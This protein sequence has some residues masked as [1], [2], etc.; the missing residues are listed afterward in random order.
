MNLKYKKVAVGGTFDLLHA[1]HKALLNKAV[2]VGE[3]VIIGI[4]TDKFIQKQTF[5]NQSARLKN[6]KDYLKNKNFKTIWLDDIFGTTLSDLE[7]EA[8]IV[9]PETKKSALLINRERLKIGLKKLDIIVVP[10]VKDEIGRTISSTRIRNGEI[11]SEGKS[12]K[13][14][15]LNLADKKLSEKIRDELKKPL[16][17]ILSLQKQG[18]IKNGSQIKFGTLVT[19]GDITTKKFLDMGINPKLAII[20]NLVNRKPFLSNLKPTIKVKSPPGQISKDL[21]LA[22]EKSIIHDS[23]FI[24][25][26]DG[27]EDLAAI[28]AIL[29]SP[30]GTNVFY[31]QPQKGLVLVNVN[32]EIKDK[33]CKLLL[34][35]NNTMV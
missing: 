24:I 22:V 23:K 5:E 2:E 4:T 29:L 9:S 13:K 21:I 28:P 35:I 18:S 27:E 19:V 25:Q 17:K 20:D 31:G 33:I 26:V 8:I 14:F 30:L 34:N 1:G 12:Y 6:L 3:Q 32:L 15:L 10:F 7:I 11:S 16:G